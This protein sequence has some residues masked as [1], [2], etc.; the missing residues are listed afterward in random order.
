MHLAG[1][2]IH[3]HTALYDSIRADIY[4]NDPYV[5]FEPYLWSF[6]HLGQRPKIQEGMTILW[7]SKDDT[8]TYVCDLV[9]VVGEEVPLSY[10]HREYGSRDT[11]L[12]N[13]H[14]TSGLKAHPKM[15]DPR[16]RTYVADMQ[17]SYI[18]HPAVPIGDAIDA[19]RGRE[20]PLRPPFAQSWRS[21]KPNLRIE[22]IDELEQYVR[23]HSQQLIR[24]A[25][26]KGGSMPN[27]C[28]PSPC[29]DTCGPSR[30]GDKEKKRDSVADHDVACGIAS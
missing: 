29:N 25:L 5:W 24:T 6:C 10:A 2:I 13:Q 30:C 12:D 19:I 14:F 23:S 4:H 1:Y 11:Y 8:A 18:P 3:H 15:R 17:R 28:D 22:A 9:F 27:T 26:S 16:A 7:V 20:Q 21:R